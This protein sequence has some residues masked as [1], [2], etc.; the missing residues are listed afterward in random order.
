MS[1]RRNGSRGSLE[2]K[3]RALEA[4]TSK[5]IGGGASLMVAG[6][7]WTE[8]Q[9][10]AMLGTL[11]RLARQRD[12]ARAAVVEA[13]L[14]YGAALPR[15]QMFIR[16]YEAALKAQ[17]GVDNAMLRDFGITPVGG[18]PKARTLVAKLIAQERARQTR[19]LHKQQATREPVT[20]RT[21]SAAADI[22]AA[23]PQPGSEE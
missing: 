8:E 23:P 5:H 17:L 10:L 6:D 4:G 9:V 11:R 14:A 20:A 22:I 15:V 13:S 7:P 3:I 2:K 16:N 19:E 1:T 12:A 21:L 18:Q